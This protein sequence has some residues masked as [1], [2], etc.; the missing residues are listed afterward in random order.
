MRRHL[1]SRPKP[2]KMDRNSP[3][4]NF[5]NLLTLPRGRGIVFAVDAVGLIRRSTTNLRSNL[6]TLSTQVPDALREQK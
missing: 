6:G 5:A 4:Q 2:G 3:K 1:I